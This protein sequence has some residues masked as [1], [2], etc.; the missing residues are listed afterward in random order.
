MFSSDREIRDLTVTVGGEVRRATWKEGIGI[1]CAG[2]DVGRGNTVEI[3]GTPHEVVKLRRILL[4]REPVMLII[5]AR[6]LG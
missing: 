4:E 3:E 6:E 2:H 5:Q 1:Y